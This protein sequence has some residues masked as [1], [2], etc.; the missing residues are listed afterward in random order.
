MV[1]SICPYIYVFISMYNKKTSVFKFALCTKKVVPVL[2]M[3]CIL[4]HGFMMK[5]GKRAMGQGLEGARDLGKGEGAFRGA[6]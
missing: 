4:L 2:F 1:V 6:F 5:G 3:L